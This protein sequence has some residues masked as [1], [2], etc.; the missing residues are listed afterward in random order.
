MSIV[1]VER[2]I[3]QKNDEVAQKNRLNFQKLGLHTINILGSPGSGKTTFLEKLILQTNNLFKTA[4][5]EG[6]LQTDLDAQRIS[7]LQIP[8]VQL[9]TNG[10]CHLEAQLVQDGFNQL[11]VSDAKLLIIENVGNL[12]CPAGFDLGEDQKMVVLSVTE[13]EEKPLKYPKI[14][15]NASVLIINK[16]DLL[17]YVKCDL[18]TMIV[19]AKS[20]NPKLIIFAVS[21]T[22]GE[23]FDA[24]IQWLK[25][26]TLTS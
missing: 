8:V 15:Q 1:T 22:T 14:F 12:V 7:A 6:D 25:E 23:G 24:V 26:F 18:N 16:I 4:V 21:S 9:V 10:A 5:I 13:G 19:N 20:I 11:D 2:K 3:L 17:P